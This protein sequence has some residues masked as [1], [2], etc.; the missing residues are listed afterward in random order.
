MCRS[1]PTGATAGTATA[2]GA[3]AGAG[4]AGEE[5]VR[6]LPTRVAAQPWLRR[7]HR[8]LLPSDT[9]GYY[10]RPVSRYRLYPTPAQETALLSHCT[11]ARY[12]VEPGG[13]AA[14]LVAAR[15]SGAWI[16]R[17]VPPALRGPCRVP[18]AG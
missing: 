2:R 1:R 13:G 12:V 10:G 11:H 14:R 17:A 16:R 18:M 6:P 4:G 15:P 3:A 5:I 8:S 7:N 9:V